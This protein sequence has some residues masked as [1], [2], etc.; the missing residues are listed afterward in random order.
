MTDE[1]KEKLKNGFKLGA[2]I[3]GL[4]LSLG[5]IGLCISVLISGAV[6]SIKSKNTENVPVVTNKVRRAVDL[7]NPYT[8]YTFN[9]LGKILYNLDQLENLQNESYVFFDTD[10]KFI[11]YNAQGSI[12]DSNDY[13][14]KC[15]LYF[16]KYN[17]PSGYYYTLDFDG[18]DWHNGLDSTK[19]MSLRYY[20]NDQSS[21]GLYAYNGNTASYVTSTDNLAFYFTYLKILG[22]ANGMSQ[23]AYQTNYSFYLNV[24][25]YLQNFI[26]NDSYIDFTFENDFN[27]GQFISNTIPYEGFWSS[28][29]TSA[30]FNSN[31]NTYNIIFRGLFTCLDKVYTEIKFEVTDC[32]DGI[33]Y[34]ID[35]DGNKQSMIGNYLYPVDM[36][37]LNK[38]DNYN[39]VSAYPYYLTYSSAGDTGTFYG[40]SRPSV[41]QAEGLRTLKIYG[42]STETL[43]TGYKSTGTDSRTNMSMQYVQKGNTTWNTNLN[44]FGFETLLTTAF[45][46]LIPLLSI[47]L[48]PGIAIGTLIFIPFIITII[49]LIVRAVK[50]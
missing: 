4:V 43:H 23:S 45:S 12:F 40:G 15:C 9:D 5:L 14:G 44:L 46:S 27:I 41:F 29:L 11:D 47:Q 38:I 35:S 36:Q 26:L 18:Y 32:R 49:I 39:I 30:Q 37:Y 10:L 42:F 13:Q 50:R 21:S 25:Q 48:I 3:S 16:Y 19:I 20:I 22:T 6:N 33:V 34:Y 24:K 7:P 17:G 8:I 31:S 2:L 28:P 1:K